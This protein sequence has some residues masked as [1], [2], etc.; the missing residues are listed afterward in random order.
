MV[1]ALR[2]AALRTSLGV[3]RDVGVNVGFDQLGSTINGSAFLLQGMLVFALLAES[4]T[5][6]SLPCAIPFPSKVTPDDRL[7]TSQARLDYPIPA[8]RTSPSQLIHC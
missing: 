5:H 6:L 1:G 3:P 7:S 4:G 2:F 8:Q